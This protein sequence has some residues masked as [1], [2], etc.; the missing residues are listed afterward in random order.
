[1]SSPRPEVFISATSADLRTCRQ[2]AK[3][4]LL[5]LGCVPVEQTNFPPAAS[6]VREMLRTRI[7]QCSAVVHIAGECY[8]AEPTERKEGEPRRSYTQLEY[9]IARELKKQVYVF[10]CGADFPYDVHAP[11]SDELRDLQ[12]A[13]RSRLQ[14]GDHLFTPVENRD[15][16]TVRVHALQTRV[17]RLVIDNNRWRKWVGLGVGTGL[18]LAA[19]LG[20]WQWRVSERNELENG[21][22]RESVIS[23]QQKMEQ[24]QTVEPN[25]RKL[26]PQER[27]ERGLAMEAAEMG[28]TPESLKAEYASRAR[29]TQ[30]DILDRA[31][32]FWGEGNFRAAAEHAERVL[33][34]V[35]Q[36]RNDHEIAMLDDTKLRL[37]EYTACKI[38]GDAYGS[39]CEY[40]RSV[41]AYDEANSVFTR[42]EKIQL[43]VDVLFKKANVLC[44]WAAASSGGDILGRRQK[45]IATYREILGAITRELMPTAWAA[46]QNNLAVAL[47]EQAS[48]DGGGQKK[49]LEEAVRAF[50]S[51]LE[52][53]TRKMM[54]EDWAVTQHGLAVALSEQAEVCDGMERTRLLDEAIQANH[55]AM[56]VRTREVMPEAWAMSQHNL[57]LFLCAKSKTSDGAAKAQLLSEAVKSFQ[58]ALEVYKREVFPQYW[59]E[60]QNNLASVLIDQAG[61]LDGLDRVHVL[62]AA[63]KAYHLALEVRARDVFP[64]DWAATQYN[65]AIAYREQARTCQG[66]DRVRLLSDSS[67]ACGLAL[68]V[69]TMEA[70]PKRWAQTQCNLAT[71]LFEQAEMAGVT[72]R[73][74]L[75]GDVIEAYRLALEVITL[76]DQ[77]Q[78]WASVK[79]DLA[80]AMMLYV[81][82]CEKREQTRV[83]NEMVQILRETLVVYT[84]A[85]FPLEW[86]GASEMIGDALAMLAE[87]DRERRDLLLEA[88]VEK[89]QCALEVYKKDTMPLEWVRVRK[90]MALVMYHGSRMLGQKG[91]ASLLE[92]IRIVLSC[93]DVWTREKHKVEWAKAQRLLA[94]STMALARVS[95]G[96]EQKEYVYL[97]IRALRNS[98]DVLGATQEQLTGLV[99]METKL[100]IRANDASRDTGTQEPNE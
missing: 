37:R 54:P 80:K 63:V 79:I 67:R 71:S 16:L 7:A 44:E 36:G 64:Q 55:E 48:V 92:A 97:S 60:T 87:V 29:D 39:L 3:E 52:V 76:A 93:F 43:W 12:D 51:S 62:G 46:T 99:E 94:D 95:S 53:R 58:L 96:E 75:L 85:G 34:Q 20:V 30:A 86:A 10:V 13:H 33:K 1:M 70:L 4:A 49:L 22:L 73:A 32:A 26:S 2:I 84:R 21:W 66:A 25:G 11:E 82:V 91:R 50:R 68:Q 47:C 18:V 90:H 23:L 8:G 9:E 15:E 100:G 88:A 98:V 40:K 42:A 5:T 77:P 56:E 59:A 19:T 83:A 14:A 61:V 78:A 6:T 45:A 57:G 72:E 89:Y 24:V 28:R 81:G 17:E 41:D 65:L 31:F 69:Y 74:G 35:H 38:L 27:Y